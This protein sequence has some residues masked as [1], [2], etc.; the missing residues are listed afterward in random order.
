M[1]RVFL[2]VRA[3]PASPPRGEA[4]GGEQRADANWTVPWVKPGLDVV[5]DCDRQNSEKPETARSKPERALIAPR[6][7]LTPAAP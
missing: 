6:P 4:N 1:N 5:G 7:P 3:A 2:D